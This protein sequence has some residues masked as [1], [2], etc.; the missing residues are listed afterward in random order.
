MIW[1]NRSWDLAGSKVS[2]RCVQAICE[3]A[4]RLVCWVGPGAGREVREGTPKCARARRWTTPGPGTLKPDRH[5]QLAN[6]GA[7]R[8]AA[9]WRGTWRPAQA[10]HPCLP[11]ATTCRA[12]T[13]DP[14]SRPTL[15]QVAV[16]SP[17]P[18]RRPQ[19][20]SFPRARRGGKV[21]ARRVASRRPSAAP[22]PVKADF[23]QRQDGSQSEARGGPREHRVP[24]VPGCGCAPP[25]RGEAARGGKMASHVE[26]EAPS[27]PPSSCVQCGCGARA[28]GAAWRLGARWA[29]RDSVGSRQTGRGWLGLAAV[30]MAWLGG[31]EVPG[32]PMGRVGMAVNDSPRHTLCEA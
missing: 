13:G 8:A 24:R 14:A 4:G 18:A 32:V 17:D 10:G 23:L 7:L 12:L 27:G 2:Q 31:R 29:R 20:G 11:R 25:G 21:R 3:A 19:L 15:N 1:S 6:G 30:G 9:L 16:Y 26:E 28:P 5:L 22:P